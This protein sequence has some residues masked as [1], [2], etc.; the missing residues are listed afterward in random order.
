[1]TAKKRDPDIAV[2][3]IADGQ[4]ELKMQTRA[5]RGIH[6]PKVKAQDVAKTED[7]KRKRF[8]V[9]LAPDLIEWAR[10]AVVFTPGQSLSGLVEEALTRELKRLEKSRGEA[11]PTTTATP[12]KGRPIILNKA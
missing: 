10:R 8:T 6:P 3:W 11:F 2:S 4:E 12:K 9:N 5:Q 7:A 1:V